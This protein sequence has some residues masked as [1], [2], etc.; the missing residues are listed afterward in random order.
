MISQWFQN[1]EVNKLVLLNVDTLNVTFFTIFILFSLFT[2]RKRETFE[3]LDQTAS[4]QVR[5]LA[6]IMVVLGHL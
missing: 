6:I 3:F 5:D 2:L 4:D 1:Y